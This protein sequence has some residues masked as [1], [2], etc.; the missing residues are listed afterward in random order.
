MSSRLS[1][2][3]ISKLFELL[4]KSY[5]PPQVL[6]LIDEINA[7][8]RVALVRNSA[9]MLVGTEIQRIEKMKQELECLYMAWVQGEIE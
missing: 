7:A 1:M 3:G 5:R 4:S 9:G 2:A 8:T 6:K